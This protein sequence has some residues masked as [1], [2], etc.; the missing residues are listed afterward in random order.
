MRLLTSSR[1]IIINHLERIS[2]GNV[3][4]AYIYCSYKEQHQTAVNILGSLLQQVIKK[5]SSVSH[6]IA[7]M[8]R[9]HISKQ[10]RPTLADYS[11]IL[12]IEILRFSKAF[13]IVDALDE[14]SENDGVWGF[15]P[16]LRKLLPTVHLLVTSR[17]ITAIE[18][19][20]ERTM[21]LEIR[22]AD[23][24][25]KNYVTKEIDKQPQLLRHIAADP[26][27]RTEIIETI[28][29]KAEGMYVFTIP[30]HCH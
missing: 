21:S 19:E 29:K 18:R 5:Q 24:D 25:I 3:I 27:L 1:S 28:V 13:I 20:F 30:V 11:N 16:E 7:T 4:V 15:L 26:R 22:A 23:G 10:T 12:Q 14:C 9:A 17:H 2:E 6:E 8:Y